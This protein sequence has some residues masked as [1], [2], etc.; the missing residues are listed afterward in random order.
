M[1]PD[2]IAPLLTAEEQRAVMERVFAEAGPDA[3][4]RDVSSRGWIAMLAAQ[5]EGGG[6]KQVDHLSMVTRGRSA[7][8]HRAGRRVRGVTLGSRN[9]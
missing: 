9:P 5:R 2:P 6:G 8:Q 1:Q 7:D 4:R 3:N